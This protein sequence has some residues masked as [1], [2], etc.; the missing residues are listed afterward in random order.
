MAQV[1]TLV[2]ISDVINISSLYIAA[3]LLTVT[4]IKQTLDSPFGQ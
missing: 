1:G 4:Y 2:S 3:K